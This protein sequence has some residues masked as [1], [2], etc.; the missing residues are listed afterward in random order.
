[1][2][3]LTLR[4]EYF[5]YLIVR[6]YKEILHLDPLK[7]IVFHTLKAILPFIIKLKNGQQDGSVGPAPVTKP[8]LDLQNSHG[9][10]RE[11]TDSCDV[12]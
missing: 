7:N 8:D 12:F 2:C 10:R 6:H 11:P 3:S 1:M 5:T 9:R 4:R